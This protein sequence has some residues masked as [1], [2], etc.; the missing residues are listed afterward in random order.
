MLVAEWGLVLTTS[1][2]GRFSEV[3]DKGGRGT[4]VQLALGSSGLECWIRY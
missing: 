1:A 3:Y 4:A 2:E